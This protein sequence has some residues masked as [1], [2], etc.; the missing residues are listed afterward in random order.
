[1]NHVQ[2]TIPRNQKETKAERSH[3]K[4]NLK[5]FYLKK[6]KEKKQ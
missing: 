3:L 2:K 5:N 4:I 1:M 6:N